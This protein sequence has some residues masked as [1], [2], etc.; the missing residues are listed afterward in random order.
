LFKARLWQ[1]IYNHK[2]DDYAAESIAY[3]YRDSRMIKTWSNEIVQDRGAEIS[4][5]KFDSLVIRVMIAQAK[6]KGWTR[7]EI[8]GGDAT[9]A[10]YFED[11]G[12]EIAKVE[13]A[14]KPAS[15]ETP[16]LLEF[17]M[18]PAEQMR[19]R[20]ERER[21]KRKFEAEERR[22]QAMMPKPRRF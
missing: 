19:R 9:I 13:E 18:T 11:A 22:R 17:A 1:Q 4:A 2:I 7:I 20:Q 15:S 5:S 16:P 14:A 6:A 8:A 3:I 21:E 12:F 10:K